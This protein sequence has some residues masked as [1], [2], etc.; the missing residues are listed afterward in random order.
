MTVLIDSSAWFDYFLGEKEGK[1]VEKYLNSQEEILISTINLTEIYS[2]YLRSWPNQAQEKK[3]YLLGRCNLIEVSKEIALEAAKTRAS[4]R[5]ALADSLI[6]ATA[7][8]SKVK[9]ITSDNDFRGLEN[10][11]IL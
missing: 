10:V 6:Y 1:I 8:L 7:K 3:N 4:K 9:L 11:E 2:R 5:L